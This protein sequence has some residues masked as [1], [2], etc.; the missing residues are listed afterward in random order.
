MYMLGRVGEVFFTMHTSLYPIVPT[1]FQLISVKN[2]KKLEYL[3]YLIV[4]Y[5]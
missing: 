5:T 1:S 2:G 3:F 4:L